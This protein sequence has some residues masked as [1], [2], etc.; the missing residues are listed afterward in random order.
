MKNIL[1]LDTGKEWGGGTNSLLEL[2]KR[3]DKSIYRYSA[4]FYTNY[5]KGQDSDIKTEIEK[6]G[7]AFQVLRHE[8]L[9]ITIKVLKEAVRIIFFFSRKIQKRTIFS[10]EYQF[11]IKKSA[12]KISSI[13]KEQSI[14]LLYMN[15]QPSSNLEGVIAAKMSHVPALQHSR[16]EARLNAFEVRT[17]NQ[18]LS[19]II[20][21]SEGV[22]KNL[23]QQGIEP[24]RCS[25]VY[26]GIDP[27]TKPLIPPSELKS[28]W[29][30]SDHDIVI[31]T[32]GSLIKRKRVNDLIEALRM[33]TAGTDRSVKCF[34]VGEGPERENLRALVKRMHLEDKV[35][36]PGFQKDAVSYINAMDIFIMTSEKEGFPRVILE[37]MLMGKP[38]VASRITGATELINN[39]ENGV[40]APL[41]DAG[42][43]TASI[44]RLIEN[45]ELRKTMG[46]N[47]RRHI[48]ENYSIEKYVNGVETVFTEILQKDRG[49]TFKIHF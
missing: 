10:L 32:V 39:G 27:G 24:S 30:V 16:I 1:I 38:V 3:I 31:G 15:N 19:R 37:A 9:P 12:E 14:D 11:R 25:V 18:W 48:L 42:K 45:P 40:L 29:K 2:L 22:K 36:F 28:R 13:I 34:I 43:F 21:V 44:I 23:V 26:N 46:E 33:T 8:K 6:L 20:C 35:I 5:K 49:Q 41:G 7:V 4:L 47:A 17:A